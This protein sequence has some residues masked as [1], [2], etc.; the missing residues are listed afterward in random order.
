MSALSSHGGGQGARRRAGRLS[1][2]GRMLR[3]CF[4][5]ARFALAPPAVTCVYDPAYEQAVPG[6]PMDPLRGEKILRFLDR[7]G[8]LGRGRV[9]RPRTPSLADI[10]RVHTPEYVDSL[11]HPETLTRVFGAPLDAR[12]AER[13]VDLHRLMTGG[14]LTA[15]RAALRGGGLVVN[16]GGGFHH[17]SR[18][19]GLGFCVFN[20]VAVAVADAR[21]R[22]FERPVLVVDLDVHDA[23][24]TR[25]IFA[26]DPSVHVY[27]IHGEDWGEPRAAAATTLAL[28][29]GVTDERYLNTLRAT[30]P[31][32]AASFQPGLVFFVAGTDPAEDDALGDWS[33]SAAALV[34]R[35]RF[36]LDLFRAR[37]PPLPL[38]MVLAGGYGHDAWRPTARTLGRLLSG[39]LIEPP[40][41][42]TLLLERF[43]GIGDSL[44]AADFAAEGPERPFE[45]SEED[46][47][48]A[49]P[50]LRAPPRFLD[51]F[52]RYGV[53]LLLERFGLLARLRDKGFSDLKV[54]LDRGPTGETLR[55]QADTRPPQ[56]L[57]ELR[58]R[59][60]Q[61][62]APGLE[63]VV[64]EWLL[65]QN[66]RAGFT[67]RRP[68]LP[69]QQ[70]PGLGLLRELL[71]W[72]TVLCELLELDGVVFTPS[73][74]H[75]ARQ[76]R[77]LVRFVHPEDEARMR[78]V[79]QAL[80]GL[81][82]AEATRAVDEQ[83]L[84]DAATGESL[85]WR[86]CAMALPV[87]A[88]FQAALSGEEYE[89]QVTAALARLTLT[90]RPAAA[91]GG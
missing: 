44:R 64:I 69:G 65:L 47:F 55:I 77:K 27:S 12:A 46:L 81:S 80:A 22:G 18:D 26:A 11:Q 41:N 87:S 23:N 56:P 8:L 70:H 15:T 17:A 61:Q 9:L 79:E 67:P 6:S 66:P 57:V 62:V 10:L 31:A 68:R 49:D 52:S 83:R 82:L 84:C 72:L 20:D 60:S 78:A 25:A 51:A 71:G 76:S 73:H 29:H 30:L 40:D 16:L 53:E 85:G 59:R 74:F 86:P 90:L 88:R 21:A 5:R 48:G 2:F 63:T 89:A 28:G 45:L 7:E 19:A 34:E 4:R 75:V 1:R 38:V 33:I 24:G 32:V 54:E 43:H 50:E 35:D 37:R 13:V 58:V 91:A 14:T 39:R 36:V 3:R 42:D